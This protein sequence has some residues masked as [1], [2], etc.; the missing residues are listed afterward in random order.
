MSNPNL[1][2]PELE[3]LARDLSQSSSVEVFYLDDQG[4]PQKAAYYSQ[5]LGDAVRIEMKPHLVVTRQIQDD[6]DPESWSTEDVSIPLE[7]V[8]MANIS[9]S[10]EW[11]P[12]G[13]IQSSQWVNGPHG[14]LLRLVP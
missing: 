6:S 10:D 7:R 14:K 12:S 4:A 8:L 13:E 9:V 11:A 1:V 2:A 5:S 3:T